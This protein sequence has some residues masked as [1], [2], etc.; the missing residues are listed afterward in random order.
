MSMHNTAVNMCQLALASTKERTGQPLTRDDIAASVDQI[1]S[2]S[3]FS[4][5]VDREALIEELEQIFTVWSNDPTAIGNDSDHMPWLTLRR[6][7]V[8]WKFWSRYRLFLINRQRLA[9]AAIETIGKVSD[10]VLGRIE[11]P[12][13]EGAWDRRGLVMG[14]VQSGKTATYTG[15]ICKAADAG[16]KVI[17]VLAGLH[18]N[19]RSQTQ[20]RVDEG[21]LGYKAAPPRD[22]GATFEPTGVAEFGTNAKADSVTNRNENG[23]FNRHIARHFGIH[24]GGH[25]LLFVVKKN[26]SIEL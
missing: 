10:E 19:L 11:D 3:M 26:G 18:N 23:D 22:G 20:V 8:D 21:F 13:R 7:D 1:L 4:G 14:N 15:L 12:Q 16:Y 24:P 5:A 17:I 2:I 9:P 25:P 6:G